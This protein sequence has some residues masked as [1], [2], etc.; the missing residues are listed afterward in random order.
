MFCSFKV[1]D[2][3]ETVDY[4]KVTT[5]L[6]LMRTIV[7]RLECS[8]ACQ[9]VKMDN[10]FHLIQ[11]VSAPVAVQQQTHQQQQTHYLPQFSTPGPCL[12]Q[13]LTSLDITAFTPRIDS[14]AVCHTDPLSSLDRVLDDTAGN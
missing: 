1:T 14:A 11:S 9:E 13:S 6:A 7:E 8:F 4:A 12:N 5:E 2:N 10:M 3:K